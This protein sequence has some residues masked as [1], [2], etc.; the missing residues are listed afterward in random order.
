VEALQK[1]LDTER[2]QNKIEM[3]NLKKTMAAATSQRDSE[4]KAR[5]DLTKKI[6]TLI[7]FSIAVVHSHSHCCSD[8]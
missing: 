3:T 5:E 2:M 7:F 6:G 8:V 1:R 4:V